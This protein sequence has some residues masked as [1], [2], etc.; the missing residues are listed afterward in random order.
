M[1]AGAASALLPPLAVLRDGDSSAAADNLVKLLN[2]SDTG[3][4]FVAIT[5]AQMADSK[6][7]T[8]AKFS[9]LLLVDAPNLPRA[10][11]Y[12]YFSFAK[13][14]AHLI[15]LGGKPPRLN[16]SRSEIGLNVMSPYEPYML[17]NAGPSKLCIAG[18]EKCDAVALPN[19]SAGSLSAIGWLFPSENRFLPLLEVQ[20]CS[21]LSEIRY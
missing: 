5:A 2:A 16:T 15:L 3:T 11:A 14:G 7:L 12:S 18:A 21:T 4:S 13:S 8:K 19:I 20:V 6:F 1:Y 9:G 10:A 17:D